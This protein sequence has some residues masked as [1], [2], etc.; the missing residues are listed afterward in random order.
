MESHSGSWSSQQ[1]LSLKGALLASAPIMPGAGDNGLICHVLKQGGLGSIVH[2]CGESL[3][4]ARIS[5]EVNGRC[6][7]VPDAFKTAS[8]H[9]QIRRN[10]S[11]C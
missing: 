8:L 4:S 2:A 1:W 3:F 10:I 11:Y 6:S 9:V 7:P 5:M